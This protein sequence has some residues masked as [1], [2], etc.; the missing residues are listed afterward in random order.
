MPLLE[1]DSASF[2]EST[3][4]VHGGVMLVGLI[5]LGVCAESIS[6]TEVI[7]LANETADGERVGESRDAL[8]ARCDAPAHSEACCEAFVSDAFMMLVLV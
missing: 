8:I 6:R 2:D 5:V 7:E 4:G 1:L 3:F